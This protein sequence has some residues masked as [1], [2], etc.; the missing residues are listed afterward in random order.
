V[1]KSKEKESKHTNKIQNQ[2]HLYYLN[3]KNNTY[4]NTNQF[5]IKSKLHTFTINAVI[6]SM[7]SRTW[8]WW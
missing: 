5:T 7:I 6:I 4:I 1:S 3:N 2:G 8:W